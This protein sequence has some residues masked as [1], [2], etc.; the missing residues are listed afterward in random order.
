MVASRR[1]VMRTP[2]SFLMA[3]AAFAGAGV[4][5]PAAAATLTVGAGKTYATPC[6]AVAAAQPNDE[7]DISPGT[8]TDTCSLPV[9]GLT[10]KGV[11]GMPKIDVSAGMP[12]GSKG[13]YNID[14]DGI[15]IENLELTGAAIS[16]GL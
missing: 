2:S 7:I 11:G 8:Y 9:A 13:I 12:A 14:A 5:V 16:S 3:F 1:T 6:A 15:T 4:A 10:L